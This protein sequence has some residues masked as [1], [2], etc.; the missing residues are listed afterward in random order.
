[1]AFTVS[2]NSDATEL[3]ISH[4]L[5]D[6]AYPLTLVLM[7]EYSCTST[8]LSISTAGVV[9]SNNSFVINLLKFYGSDTLKARIDDGVYK[10]TLTFSY[11]DDLI[12][13][14]DNSVSTT[15]CFVVDYLLKCIV[16]NNNTP[17]VLDKYRSMFFATDCD[18]C[19]CTNLCTIYNDLLQT[20]TITNA[21]DCGCN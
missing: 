21:T 17:E 16:L 11:P 1:M 8:V 3:T 12:P 19:D 18:D 7:A 14:Q 10:F 13:E 15:C 20:P 4:P 2:I 9:I 6:V 5:L